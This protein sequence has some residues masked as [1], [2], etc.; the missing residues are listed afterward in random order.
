MEP[1]IHYEEWSVWDLSDEVILPAI[2]RE[3]P[4]LDGVYLLEGQVDPFYFGSSKDVCRRIR[5]HQQHWQDG[6]CIT[7]GRDM[8]EEEER[9]ILEFVTGLMLLLTGAPTRNRRLDYPLPG[10]VNTDFALSY[11]YKALVPLW[12]EFGQQIGLP[13]RDFLAAAK[14]VANLISSENSRQ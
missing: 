10:T 4:C 8:L 9:Q 6:L 2:P 12:R 14:Q 3:L 1:F 13:K 7:R 5:N 11:L